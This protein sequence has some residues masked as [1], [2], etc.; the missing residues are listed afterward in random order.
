VTESQ[1]APSG[2]GRTDRI[3]RL[4]AESVKIRPPACHFQEPRNGQVALHFAEGAP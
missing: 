3:F 1:S 2:I 4:L